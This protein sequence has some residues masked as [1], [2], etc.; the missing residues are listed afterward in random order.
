MLLIKG[1]DVVLGI[2]WLQQL[3]GVAHVYSELTMEF[4]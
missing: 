1:L 3:G 4:C 2:Q